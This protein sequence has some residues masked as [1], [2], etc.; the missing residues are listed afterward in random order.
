MKNRCNFDLGRFGHPGRLGDAPGRAWNVLGAPSWAV[1]AA[2]LAVLAASSGVRGTKLAISSAKL[3][4][5]GC[6]RALADRVASVN[7]S[8][9]SFRSEFS[10][11][12]RALATSPKLEIHSPTQCFVRVRRSCRSVHIRSDEWQR[13][14]RSGFENRAPERPESV[15]GLPGR[16]K[17][18][19]K[20]Q[21]ERH[22]TAGRIFFCQS[23]AVSRNAWAETQPNEERARQSTRIPV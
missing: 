7:P 18:S 9:S 19:G 5:L 15:S 1:L 20:T 16:A 22:R 8:P 13:N 17:S 14:R 4:L 6:F 3:A 2:K 10:P 12:V 11:D 23:S 21:P